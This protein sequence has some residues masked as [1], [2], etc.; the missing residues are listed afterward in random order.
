MPIS[1]GAPIL[2]FLTSRTEASSISSTVSLMILNIHDLVHVSVL[3]AHD[4][5][6]TW[7]RIVQLTLRNTHNVIS[8]SWPQ[9]Y[10]KGFRRCISE[11]MV[12]VSTLAPGLAGV[13]LNCLYK[14]WQKTLQWVLPTIPSSNLRN[15]FT[16]LF[17]REIPLKA[18]HFFWSLLTLLILRGNCKVKGE[19][20]YLME[21][22]YLTQ[23]PSLLGSS[24]RW[25]RAIFI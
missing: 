21:L 4:V 15:I 14:L 3:Y 18:D 5:T 17:L 8:S 24:I 20:Q 25:I 13:L 19:T 9:K 2:F 22:A 10:W 16:L 6:L 12:Q 7:L 1:A 11:Q 23:S